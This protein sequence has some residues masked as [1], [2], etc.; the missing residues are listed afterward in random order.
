VG[1]IDAEQAVTWNIGITNNEAR[2]L[3]SGKESP[4]RST[5]AAPE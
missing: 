2:M 4:R 3:G 1:I 5:V